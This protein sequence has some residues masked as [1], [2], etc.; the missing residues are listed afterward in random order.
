M[1]AQPRCRRLLFCLP[2]E[3]W[4][5][6]LPA[7]DTLCPEQVYSL[8]IIIIITIPTAIRRLAVTL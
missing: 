6:P 8:H 7:V 1:I 5:C 3:S 2:R 4:F